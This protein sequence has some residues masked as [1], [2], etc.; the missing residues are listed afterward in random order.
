MIDDNFEES[1]VMLVNAFWI[2]LID[3]NMFQECMLAAIDRF[4]F[5]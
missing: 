5:G 4:I 2:L 3:G 1:I